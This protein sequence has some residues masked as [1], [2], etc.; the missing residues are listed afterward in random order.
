MTEIRFFHNAAD[1]LAAACRIIATAYR[2]GR[3][4]T[5]FAPDPTLAARLDALLWN[6]P[7]HAF[8]PH[9]AATSPLAAETAVLIATELS[10]PLQQDV[11]VNLDSAPP[12][13]FERFAQV[14]EIVS[15]DPVDAQQA[16]S[17]WKQYSNQG[18]K[19]ESNDLGETA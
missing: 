3:S 16:R 12:P 8:L 10:A 18:L 4:V 1:K 17:R 2:K 14:I 6:N 11:L 5:V 9:V 13:G 15:H 19:P 7:H